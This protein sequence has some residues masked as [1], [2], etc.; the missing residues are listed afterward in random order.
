[1]IL[2]IDAGNTR[3]KWAWLRDGKLHL[4][5]AVATGADESERWARL[6]AQWRVHAPP[7]RVLL[8]SVLGPG[9]DRWLGDG[10][11]RL[12]GREVERLRPARAACGITTA[13]DPNRLGVDR[14]LGLLGARRH[15]SAPLLVV[16]CGSAITVDA[17]MAGGRHP[18]GVIMPG[19]NLLRRSLAG[20]G[21]AVG[22]AGEE[23]DPGGLAADTRGAVLSGTLAAAL[24][25]IERV[26][27]TTRRR[28]RQG[29]AAEAP[30]PVCFLTGGDGPVLAPWLTRDPGWQERP[31]LVF[32]GM[33]HLVEAGP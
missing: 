24:G 17:L 23:V 16:D 13:C 19:L 10:I 1:M 30:A 25:G 31:G 27:A 21:L 28:L 20:L 2:L 29:E 4:G 5:G 32:E 6:A 3:L 12:W 8:A 26:I 33:V 18:G 15:T 14:W 7:R 11:G 22:G 9:F